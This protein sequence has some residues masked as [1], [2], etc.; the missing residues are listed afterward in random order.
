MRRMVGFDVNTSEDRF[1]IADTVTEESVV[2]ALVVDPNTTGIDEVLDPVPADQ[3][4]TSMMNLN[5][6]G[7]IEMLDMQG[8][9]A[10]KAIGF[11][12]T[13]VGAERAT[14]S[15][16]ADIPKVIATDNMVIA[17]T[18][19]LGQLRLTTKTN[20]HTNGID[21]MQLTVFN[22]PVVTGRR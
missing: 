20:I 14:E 3:A 21:V 13:T 19:T 18:G 10:L 22:N 4:A 15:S 17:S 7:L 12:Q 2:A 9:D 6:C 1:H 5:R 11:D 16:Q 8:A